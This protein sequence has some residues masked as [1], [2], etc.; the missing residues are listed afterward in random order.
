[1]I[2]HD[3]AETTKPYSVPII[4]LITDFGLSDHYVGAMKG[5]IL[6]ICPNAQIIDLTH[7]ID[8]QNVQQA[9]FVLL[10][11]YQYLPSGTIIIAVIDPGVGSSRKPI[12]V[13]TNMGIFVGPDNGLFSYVFKQVEVRKIV[14]LQNPKYLLNDVS[15]TF[16]GRDIFSPAGAHL[17][18]GV[19]IDE[20]GPVM[21]KL[22][23]L[24]TPRFEVKA[25][26]IHG[27]VLYIDRFGNMVTSI[28][29]LA[30]GEN[31]TLLVN[32]I[33]DAVFDEGVGFP[34]AIHPESCQI[35]I[36]E[37]ELDSLCFSYSN[38]AKGN[39]LALVNSA[40]HLEIAV[41][42]GNAAKR[43]GVEVGE[44]VVLRFS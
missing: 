12:A 24:E 26:S 1:M 13:E 32:P 35:Q 25:D 15:S 21:N 7:A 5:V 30:W 23:W 11:S 19:T 8:P 31:D 37:L 27:E 44:P 16:H 33:F 36:G 22:V 28:G 17:A 39:I 14:A 10:N 6:S 18:R 9:A 20:L 43:L 34:E 3:E 38:A 41:N 4:A 29:H 42:Q 40:R 2:A